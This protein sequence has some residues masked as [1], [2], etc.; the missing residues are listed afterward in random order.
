MSWIS[1]CNVLGRLRAM[2]RKSIISFAVFF[3]LNLK[4]LYLLEPTYP[5]PH[6]KCY[7][8][9]L[10]ID[11]LLFHDISTLAL[12]IMPSYNSYA[13]ITS[14]SMSRESQ[15]F[16]IILHVLPRFCLLAEV[17]G[18]YSTQSTPLNPPLRPIPTEMNLYGNFY[19]V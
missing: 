19:L 3:P 1:I 13:R 12:I 2:L 8:N 9:E 4:L 14:R 16:T 7:Y 17:K 18:C 11:D 10:W 6:C 5:H 15:Q